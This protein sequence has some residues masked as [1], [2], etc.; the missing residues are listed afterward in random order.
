MK[1]KVTILTSKS[2]PACPTAKQIWRKIKEK[3]DF[4][5][6]EI[7]V[8]SDN[9]QKII[10]NEGIMSVPTTIIDGKIIFTGIPDEKKAE[11]LI[12]E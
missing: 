11:D 1:H 7:D 3:N 4:D 6:E 8:M 10:S 5:Y 12:K 2:C 9:G